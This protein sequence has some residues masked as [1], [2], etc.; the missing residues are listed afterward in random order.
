[1]NKKISGK[2]G[3][4]I[5]KVKILTAVILS[6]V[7]VVPSYAEVMRTKITLKIENNFGHTVSNDFVDERG[8]FTGSRIETRN[9]ADSKGR[10]VTETETEFRNVKG[11]LL[12]S[13][14]IAITARSEDFTVKSGEVFSETF[15]VDVTVS[16]FDRKYNEYSYTLGIE[17]LP[18]GLYVSGELL[19]ADVLSVG[20]TGHH[21]EFAVY[22]TPEGL[23]RAVMRFTAVV[24][25]SGD[26]PVMRAIG[27]KDVT[28]SAE[29]VPKPPDEVPKSDDIVPKP[30]DPVPTPEDSSE[31]K[32]I[33]TDTGTGTGTRTLADA[34]RGM[35]AEEKAQVKAIK[36][37][38]G[39]TDLTGLE[40]FTNLER[41]DLTEADRLESV[42]L[43]GNSS[44][45]SVDIKGNEA[46]KT[47][48]IS[49]SRVEELD[50]S[51][52]ENLEEVDVSGCT[53]LKKLNVSNTQITALNAE[54]CTSLE[55]LDCSSC[56][57]EE[58]RLTGCDSLNVL[59][60]SNNR[61]HRLDVYT[62][63]K[64]IELR[65]ENQVIHGPAFGTVMNFA[66][67]FAGISGTHF[68]SAADSSE[69]GVENV[70]NLRAWDS[71]G[72][73]VSVEYDA[74]TGTAVFGSEPVKI[75]YDYITGFR[76]V[77]MDVAVFADEDSDEWPAGTIPSGSGCNTVTIIPLLLLML[78]IMAAAVKFHRR[79]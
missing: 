30:P 20:R 12:M 72:N 43:R 25:V 74:E 42:D 62:M 53:E 63:M 37:N 57:I 33:G 28:V 32:E 49:G 45:K 51:G 54:G 14:D 21:H 18:E 70:I 55:V 34:T 79:I 61:L 71:S 77:R 75:A 50:A 17:G 6:A 46:L 73:E 39:I 9:F 65:C 16:L 19:S 5:M 7:L 40:E 27:S 1:M 60:C 15:S 44:V 4:I 56:N 23:D 68:G 38:S 8:I 10:S 78:M 66:E 2:K 58:L 11:E 69:S 47:L 76:D 59:D 24:Y 31:T 29:V 64:L 67:Y 52:C 36:I 41:L 26:L 35:T 3:G 48:D 13:A 22:G